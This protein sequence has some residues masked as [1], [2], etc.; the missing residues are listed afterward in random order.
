VVECEP[1]IQIM[2][3]DGG[4]ARIAHQ[5]GRLATTV[6]HGLY[7][8]ELERAGR[9]ENVLVEHRSETRLRPSG[10]ELRTA[11]LIAGAA[12][13]HD[14]YTERAIALS[15]SSTAAALGAAPHTGHLLIFIRREARDRGPRSVPSEPISI[16]DRDGRL[17]AAPS[18][19]AGAASDEVG[20]LAFA[21]AVAPGTYRLRATRSRRD[22]AITVP[23]GR[24]A[25][26]FAADCGVI[27]LDEVRVFL[28]RTG[29]GYDPASPV[30]H[31]MEAVLEAL[32]S[33]RAGL[34]SSVRPLLCDARIDDLMLDI[35]AAH[36]LLRGHGAEDGPLLERVMARL[37]SSAPALPDV[38]ILE[39]AWHRALGKPPRALALAAPPM[40]RASF[41]LAM[42]GADGGVPYH[43]ALSESARGGY[44]DSV[45]WTWSARGFDARWVEPAVDGLLAQGKPRDVAS[46]AR[47]IGVP[48]TTV[49]HAIEHIEATTPQLQ[50]AP[51]PIEQIDIAGY[52]GLQLVQRGAH[53]VVLRG[54]REREHRAVALK[55]VPGIV[56]A[57]Q[58]RKEELPLLGRLDPHVLAFTARGSLFG[59][60]GMW[61]EMELCRESLLDTVL[62]RGAPLAA[63]EATEYVVQ[64]LQG[65]AFLHVRGIAHGDL[66]PSNL[67]VRDD[68]RVAIGDVGFTTRLI[69]TG[70]L[71]RARALDSIRFAPR[72]QLAEGREGLSVSDV[73]SMAATLYFLISLELPRE[74]YSNQ[75]ELEAAR[76]NA[77][78]PIRERLSEVPERL[79]DCIDRALSI[80]LAYRPRDAAE[81]ARQLVDAIPSAHYKPVRPQ[82]QRVLERH[83]VAAVRPIEPELWAYL[84]N[85]L[86][87]RRRLE[88][89][90]QICSDPSLAA[91]VAALR[92]YSVLVVA[93]PVT[94][95]AQLARLGHWIRR[96]GQRPVLDGVEINARVFLVREGRREMAGGPDHNVP[97][98]VIRAG[99]R[100]DGA[101]E[102]RLGVPDPVRMPSSR[103]EPR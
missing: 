40:L 92:P 58:R 56:A 5:H 18:D 23:D 38:A 91:K 72:E 70:T 21:A 82:S 39:Y 76:H 3:Y 87:P 65:L 6:P 34:P 35:A 24:A 36:L 71:Q 15:R 94:K 84:S 20:Y 12:T 75:T 42:S 30:G 96:E 54:T 41:L 1:D 59:G 67:L 19:S 64:A 13:S 68:G 98:M 26:V 55:I 73:W 77:V 51:L 79:A 101:L 69:D 86:A 61:F 44:H 46:I 53:G 100:E 48:A 16:L 57:A 90:A 37:L 31:A 2:L 32:W 33:S 8:V 10:P 9:V 50:G 4:G 14:Y 29:R 63:G 66:K 95:Y 83:V 85:E 60:A 81:L 52:T 22:F 102:I 45:W 27:R 28:P 11:A 74:T 17:V 99:L 7:R 43:S 97:C 62:E 49:E 88:L 103:A 25:Q 78:V 47:A 93:D 89:D 80:D